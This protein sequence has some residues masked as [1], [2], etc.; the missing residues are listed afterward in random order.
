VKGHAG[1][2]LLDAILIHHGAM[3]DRRRGER[4]PSALAPNPVFCEVL[5][6]FPAG[7]TVC[8]LSAM[9]LFQISPNGSDDE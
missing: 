2:T 5:M 4:S 8:A 7:W 1:S 9:P 3:Q 6:G